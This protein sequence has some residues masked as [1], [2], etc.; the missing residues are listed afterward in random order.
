MSSKIDSKQSQ[1]E[2]FDTEGNVLLEEVSKQIEKLTNNLNSTLIGILDDPHP[3]PI[4][5]FVSQKIHETKKNVWK[6]IPKN[7]PK[8]FLMGDDRFEY[9]IIPKNNNLSSLVFELKIRKKWNSR[10]EKFKI[11]LEPIWF[12]LHRNVRTDNSE[13]YAWPRFINFKYIIKGAW[14]GKNVYGGRGDYDEISNI[15]SFNYFRYLF[16][17]K[18]GTDCH[19]IITR[20]IRDFIDFHYRPSIED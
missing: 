6:N 9:I 3:T 11:A 12:T 8:E 4:N 17:V 5:S 14:T 20:E 16:K 18:N 13:Y 7:N 15:T 2:M 19:A 10:Y 1:I